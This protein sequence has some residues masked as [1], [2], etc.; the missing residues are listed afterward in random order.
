MVRA[1][2]L[3]AL[4]VASVLLF[5]GC[6]AAH[7]GVA[8]T[9]GSQ[10]ITVA[11][12][13]DFAQALC[14]INGSGQTST[15]ARNT[16]LQVLIFSELAKQM[17]AQQGATFDNTQFNSQMT[18]AAG[19]L[20]SVSESFRP[21][22][23]GILEDYV[24]GGLQITDLGRKS[25]IA[26]GQASPDDSSSSQEGQRL[27]MSSSIPVTVDPRFGSWTSSGLTAGSGSLSVPVSSAALATGSLPP[28]GSCA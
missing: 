3:A 13:D 5:A 19:L 21:T 22:L 8:A 28:F 26:Q 14:Q 25:L 9:V 16:A 1:R 2:S 4:V 10:G 17:A 6:G 23:Q 11:Q 12:V 24:R 7:P 27:L 20:S 15:Q 18:Q